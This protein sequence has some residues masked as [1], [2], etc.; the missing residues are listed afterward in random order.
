MSDREEFNMDN[1]IEIVAYV[2]CTKCKVFNDVG[3]ISDN[4]EAVEYFL[5]KGWRATEN[6][7]YCPS[8]AKKHLKPKKK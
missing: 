5:E 4:Y 2:K 7:T 6:N 8:C 3:G 1:A